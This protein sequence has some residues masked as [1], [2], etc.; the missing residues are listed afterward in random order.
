MIFSNY[1]FAVDSVTEPVNKIY[2]FPA[3][4]FTP[5][6]SGNVNALAIDFTTSETSTITLE[7]EGKFKY[8]ECGTVTTLTI[9]I[10]TTPQLSHYV[11]FTAGE[12]GATVSTS[13]VWCSE[14]PTFEANKTYLLEII[15][16]YV[17]LKATE[18][19]AV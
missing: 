14:V 19:P 17:S 15:G 9:N 10:P 1:F 5:D 2:K 7:N 4:G 3:Y 6:S 18:S 16:K 13:L 11:R 8:I 12:S